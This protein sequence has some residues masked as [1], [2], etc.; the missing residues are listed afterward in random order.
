VQ[1]AKEALQVKRTSPGW[2]DIESVEAPAHEGEE[3]WYAFDGDTGTL[4]HTPWDR[5]AIGE[6]GTVTF[7]QPLEV[8]RFEYVPRQDGANGRL[9]KGNLVL[10][11]ET[12]KEHRFEFDGW[13]NDAT[14]KVIPFEKPIKIKKAT[15]TGTE[16][17]G[18]GGAFQSAAEL[19]FV[20]P[21]VVD[22]PLDM[23][24]YQAELARV[25]GIDSEVARQAATAVEA[26]YQGLSQDNLIT[27]AAL[28]RLVD[29][30]KQIKAPE[31]SQPS[32]PTT[33]S[34]PSQPTTPS[35]PSQPTTPSQPSQVIDTADRLGQAKAS[36]SNKP[37][38]MAPKD[39]GQS[40][41]GQALPDTGESSNLLVLGA[42]I[43]TAIAGIALLVF[44]RR[45]I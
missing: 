32:Q 39:N 34:Q 9:K 43:M 30:L 41:V 26:Y 28:D 20:L 44:K 15:I 12:G 16:S 19:R 7:K 24:T 42:A 14:T 6:S 29:Y 25:K 23:T 5:R 31:P 13:A 22:T 17:Y 27:K 2:D 37:S 10:V 36:D 21:E 45:K 4:W 3:F 33:P 38:E 18:D 35:Q 40:P 1:A 11:D 8:T